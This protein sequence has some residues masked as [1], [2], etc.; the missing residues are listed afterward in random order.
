MQ[1]FL[2]LRSGVVA[3]SPPSALLHN[4]DGRSSSSCLSRRVRR[5][6]TCS[7]FSDM[8]S[9]KLYTSERCSAEGRSTAFRRRFWL[10]PHTEH[11]LTDS[12]PRPLPSGQVDGFWEK[13]WGD[14]LCPGPAD[15]GSYV[16]LGSRNSSLVGTEAVEGVDV[17]EDCQGRCMSAC[18]S[19]IH[20]W[21]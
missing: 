4:L 9:R 18:C 12:T 5:V 10:R 6:G 14:T 1:L 3:V 19:H 21:K 20:Y 16:F 7:T 2:Q 13:A 15:T 8:I 17:S 11:Q